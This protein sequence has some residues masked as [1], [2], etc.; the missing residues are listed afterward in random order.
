VK[1]SDILRENVGLQ[2]LSLRQIQRV[3]SG[4]MVT[5]TLLSGRAHMGPFEFWRKKP[6]STRSR[7]A[8]LGAEQSEDENAFSLSIL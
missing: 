5:V 4:H 6:I 1:R 3:Y 8:I 2:F 7:V